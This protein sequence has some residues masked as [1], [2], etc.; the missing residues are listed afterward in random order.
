MVKSDRCM[1]CITVFVTLWRCKVVSEACGGVRAETGVWRV[2]SD[3]LYERS[4]MNVSCIMYHIHRLLEKGSE[5]YLMITFNTYKIVDRS[6][7]DEAV[8]V[9]VPLAT[10][11]LNS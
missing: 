9:F 8:L 10:P 2:E 7:N 3:L 4:I 11:I 6:M 1:D 5:C